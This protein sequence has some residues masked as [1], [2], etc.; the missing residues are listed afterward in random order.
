MATVSHTPMELDELRLL[1]VVDNETDTLSSIDEGVPQIPEAAGLISR[2]PSI[3]EFNGHACKPIFEHL[4]CAC[5][6]FSALVTGRRG[7][8]EHSVL[9]DVGPLSRYLAGQCQAA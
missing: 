7:R 9:F 4:C 8:E 1:I 5:H 2:I 6:G 3:H